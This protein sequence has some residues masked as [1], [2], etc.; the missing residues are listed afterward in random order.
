MNQRP[1]P[2]GRAYRSNQ[3]TR[4][5]RHLPLKSPTLRFPR[6]NH[7]PIRN[8]QPTP[9]R[10]RARRPP[11]QP[12]A[13]VPSDPC[14]RDWFWSWAWTPWRS[15]C[16]YVVH[17][18]LMT[19]SHVPMA[20]LIVFTLMI[21]AS[22]HSIARFFPVEAVIGRNGTPFWPW[23][24]SARAVPGFGLSGYLLGYI[25]TPYYFAHRSQRM[26]HLPASV[27]QSVAD[28]VR[29]KQGG[30]L[31]FRRRAQR[32]ADPMGTRGLLPLPLVDDVHYGGICGPG[33]CRRRL[34]Q[35]NGCRTNDWPFRPWRR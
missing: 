3:N 22:A 2:S 31:V 14:F 16:R 18:S 28:P 34:S 27:H 1:V 19:Y 32:R 11:N 23:A 9:L 33:L 4:S 12:A 30:H 17:G 29:R 5:E 26:E 7:W 15:T 8:V 35:S 24:S 20:M 10:Q 25:A 13:S 6:P 21:M